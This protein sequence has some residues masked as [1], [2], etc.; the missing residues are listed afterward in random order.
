MDKIG[1]LIFSQHKNELDLLARLAAAESLPIYLVGGC[2]RDHLLKRDSAD[3]DF[4]CAVDP[5]R[6]AQAF[7]KQIN[8]H[9]FYLDQQRGYSRVVMRNATKLQ[10]DFAPF[11]GPSLE[12]DLALRDFTINAMA[13]PLTIPLDT[14]AL[15]DPLNGQG[16]LAAQRLRMCGDS[17]IAADPLRILKGIRHC[18]KL[19]LAVDNVTQ[20]QFIAHAPLL[21]QVA[22]ERIRSELSQLF[23]AI[24]SEAALRMLVECDVAAAL[25]LSCTSAQIVECHRTIEHRIYQLKQQLQEDCKRQLNLL[26]G[27]GFTVSGLAVFIAIMRCCAVSGDSL[28]GLLK[29]LHFEKRIA[30]LLRF[31]LNTSAAQFDKYRRLDCSERGKLLWLQHHHAPLPQALI[32]CQLLSSGAIDTQQ[33]LALQHLWQ[34]S[35]TNGRMQP[36]LPAEYIQQLVPHCKGQQ[37]GQCLKAIELA[38]ING[39]VAN[40][41]DGELYLD[42]WC[43]SN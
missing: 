42:K 13:L 38:E 2:L 1:S 39:I 30:Q 32:F 29:W 33:L 31:F 12:I 26:C 43:E 4:V 25:T 7:A 3:Y 36:L 15:I 35:Q 19:N 11:R 21:K 9:W 16:D 34:Q 41:D 27:D 14:S 40:I 17:V 6:I 37:L 5:S 28:D 10:F 22:G 8:A 20:Q 24:N 23:A 18:A